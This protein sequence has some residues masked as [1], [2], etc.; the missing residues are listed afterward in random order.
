MA[1]FTESDLISKLEASDSRGIYSLVSDYLSPF[2]DLNKTKKK[3]KK[4]EAQTSIR[5]LGKKFLPFLNRSF[6]IL[7]K[8]IPEVWKSGGSEDLVLELFQIYRLCLDCLDVVAPLL[9]CKPYLVDLE[10]VRMMH[11][12]AK[13]DRFRDAELEGLRVLDRVRLINFIYSK[14]VKSK[15]KFLPEVDRGGGGDNDFVLMVVEVVVTLVKCAAMGESKEGEYFRTVLDLV[16]EVRPWLRVSDAGASEKWHA[17][18]V[19]YL[20]RCAFILV[21]KPNFYDRDLLITFCCTTLTEYVKSSMK[22]QFYKVAYRICSSLFMHQEYSL[23]IMDIL[24]CVARECKAGER[25]IGREFVELVSYCANK[26]QS[27]NPTFCSKFAH[28]LNNV[29]EHFRKVLLPINLILR[30]Y[31]AGLLLTNCNLRAKDDGTSRSANFESMVGTLLDN[32]NILHKLPAL[33]GPLSSELNIASSTNCMTS[34][35]RSKDFASQLW[36]QLGCDRETSSTYLPY[37]IDALKFV[38]QPLAV[39]V[40]SEKKELL[41]KRDD[42]IALSKL[43]TIQDVFHHLCHLILSCPSCTSGKNGNESDENLRTLFNMS[44]AAFVLSMKTNLNFQKSK[45]LLKYIIARDGIPTAGLKYLSAHLHQISVVLYRDKQEREAAKVLSLCCKA[46]WLYINCR[47]D[48]QSEGGYIEFATETC[49]RSALL[50]DILEQVDKQKARRKIVEILKYWSTANDLFEKLPSPIQIVKQWVKM[51]CRRTKQVDGKDDS[52]TLYCLMSSSIE[53]SKRNIGIILEQELTTYEEMSFRYPEFCQRMQ[54]KIIGILLQD[55]YVMPDSYLQRAQTLV[56]KGKASRISGTEGLKDCIQCF[57][58]AITMIKGISSQICTSTYQFYHQLALAY[59][60]R[61]LC[62]QEAEPNSV[63]IFQDIK[64]ALNLW[65]SIPVPD[66]YEEEG[67]SVLSDN[68][69]VLLYNI[70]DLLQLKGGSMELYNDAYQLLIRMFKL[71]NVSIE[72]WLS[73][74]WECRRISHALCALPVDETFIM[75]LL[76]QFS[77][78]SNINCW[79][80][81]LQGSQPL[82]I[83]FQQNFSFLFAGSTFCNFEGSFQT[84][85]TVEEIQK[86]ALELIS[87]VPVP[88]HSAFLAG[89]LYYDMCPRLISNGRLTE[90]LQFAKEAHGLC[91]RLFQEK[92]SCTVRQQTKEYSVENLGVKVSVVREVLLFD[93][94]SWDLNSCYLS[95]WKI[96]QCYLESTLQVGVIHEQIGNGAEAEATLQLGKSISY[97][98]KLSSFMVAFSSIL[99]KLYGKKRLWDLAE[100][101]LQNAKQVLMDNSTSFCCLK[102]KLMLEVITYQYLGDLYQSKLD[103]GAGNSG[104]TVENWYTAA[105]EKLNLSEWKNPLSCPEDSSDESLTDVKCVPGKTA[106]CIT[107]NE[108]DGIKSIREGPETKIGVK[109]NRKTR[110]SVKSLP[111]DQSLLFEGNSRLTRSRYRSS[112]NQQINSS[113]MSEVG[114]SKSSEGNNISDCSNML[115]QEL[116]S[117]KTSSSAASRCEM[118]C[119]C[120]KKGSWH[121]LP[122]EAMKSGLLNDFIRLKWEFVRRQLSMKLLTRIVKCFTYPG[123]M[124]EIRKVLLSSISVLVSRNPFSHTFPSVPLDYFRDMVA[125]EIPGDL[126]TI[127][128][129]EILHEICWFSLKSYHLKDNR[130]IFCNLPCIKFED[131]AYWL[132]LAFVLSGEFPLLFQKVST[133]LAV[134]FIVS[135][136]S[137]QLSLSSFSKSL[138]DNYWATYFHQASI[139]THLAYQFRSRASGR[140]QHLVDAE[141]QYVIGSSCMR[142]G[143]CDLLR[144]APETTQDLVEY[145]KKFSLG[146]PST[147]VV[148]IKLLGRDYAS[149]LQGLLPYPAC[150]NAWMVVSRLSSKN[151]PIVTLLPVDSIL[152]AS[153]DGGA[154]FGLDSLPEY[155]K[156]SKHWDCPWGFA[157]VDDVAP[158]FRMILENNYISSSVFPLEDTRENRNLW[159]KQR[160]KLDQCLGK[161]L[162]NLEDSWFGSW[163]WLLLGEW[164]NYKNLDAVHKKLV[165]DLKSKCKLDVN[166]GLLKVFL[167]NSKYA[168]EGETWL[169][170]LCF[171]KGCYL[172]KVGYCEEVRC[173]ISSNAASGSGMPSEVSLELLNEALNTLEVETSVVGEPVILVL[174][175]EVQMLPWENLPILRKQEVYRMPSVSSI[176]AM[177]ERS[178][179]DPAQE[180]RTSPTFPLI[181]PLDAFYLLNPS[182]DLNNTQDEFENWFRC[183][184]IEGKAGSIPT[185][186]ELAAA[187]TNHDLFLYFGHGSGAQYIPRHEIQKLQKC[188]ATLLMGCSSGSLVLHG[189]YAPQGIPLSY[190]LAGSPAI[191]ANLWEVTDKDIDR[192]G[193]AMLDAWLRERLNFPVECLQCNLITEELEAMNLKGCKGKGKKVSKKKLQ[194]VCETDSHK[195]CDHRPKI[196]SFMGQAREA[197][198]LPYLIG[199][200]PVCYGVPTGIWKK[201][202]LDC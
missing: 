142:E 52:L 2:A 19:G 152:Q 90:A 144:L 54:M 196:G 89:Y 192:F 83:G 147:T 170:Q 16:E 9:A 164:L 85:I 106:T 150:V 62:T 149:L 133:L 190:L 191:V 96:M 63:E 140:C 99:G 60:L 27:A 121:S 126:F 136:S 115:S 64:E 49:S 186:E 29:A 11:C 18:L 188:A 180:G 75:K 53:L 76:D 35:V 78:L 38:C 162:R 195:N 87:N 4:D 72:K 183:Q 122:H 81:Y 194:E 179:N 42:G 1:S 125:R 118:T 21:G 143:T 39:S 6:S 92:F 67:C 84:N 80:R 45:Q 22:D 178:R 177:F 113:S 202:N 153:D 44:V 59:S 120:N 129:A 139:G 148:N 158:T 193:K 160:K 101:E 98:M 61:A 100:K 119:N 151:E 105:L 33:L 104:M 32:E 154:N 66:N 173:C 165:R 159:W 132:M 124:D 145:V 134:M 24:D 15:N 157:V 110:N 155:E 131:L 69:L 26:C 7:P 55:V 82:L 25:N 8:R 138:G 86:A 37:Y 31:A 94:N 198:I 137:E 3:A 103:S 146:L 135:A 14:S 171:K 73:L 36:A 71:K 91:T 102:C 185:V 28:Y 58:E 182:G 68:I 128:R 117:K 107:V 56:R 163:N 109:Q 5:S 23:Y 70:I 181:D 176:S 48:H 169:S 47:Y 13:C 174:D 175:Y 130:N 93:S 77:A 40:N 17:A 141:G 79:F 95:P 108:T 41:A 187:L 111:K 112:Q 30:L 116:H 88:T 10:R 50:F 43:S 51:E 114:R 201:R 184:N 46:S 34:S 167:G 200:S 166:E 97:S 199:A 20:G 189:S 65:L 156:L 197:C 168:Y 74:L 172:A 12:L 127:E 161:L 123:Q 57:S